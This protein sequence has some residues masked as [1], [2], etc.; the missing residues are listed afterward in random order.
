MKIARLNVEGKYWKGEYQ[1]FRVFVDDQEIEG[2]SYVDTTAGIVRTY[3]IS[4]VL[5]K[6]YSGTVK[7]I[8]PPGVSFHYSQYG[9][10]LK[11]IELLSARG[12][13]EGRVLDIGAWQPIDKSNTAQLIENGF[14]GVLVEPSPGPLKDLVQFYKDNPNIEIIG[15]P[16][17]PH[18]GWVKLNLTDDALSTETISEVWREQG[19]YFGSAWYLSISVADLIARVGGDFQVCSIDTEGSSC[20]VFAE[21]LKTGARPRIVILEHDGRVVE[22]FPMSEAANYRQASLNGTNII[23][24]WQ[25]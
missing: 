16:I 11:A 4:G 15:A 9:E 5:M 20:E 1:G 25:G 22:L 18:G 13:T 12:I 10:D 3:H 23:L 2:A 24:E 14:G 19:G 8:P 7:L 17:T 6:E 21:L